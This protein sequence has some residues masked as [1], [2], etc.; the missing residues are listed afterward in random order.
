MSL[1]LIVVL[2]ASKIPRA[3][4]DTEHD[5][6]LQP[7]SR[8]QITCSLQTRQADVSA[9]T[10]EALSATPDR[11]ADPPTPEYR[12]MSASGCAV[13]PSLSVEASV[14]VPVQQCS[15]ISVLVTCK[16]RF[17]LRL[18]TEQSISEVLLVSKIITGGHDRDRCT[19]SK[20]RT[21]VCPEKLQFLARSSSPQTF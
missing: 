8:Q 9:S 13:A 16:P 15:V 5:V 14:V 19:N 10:V 7:V 20:A 12:S 4:Q 18:L 21:L 11:P 2:G 3:I 6:G 17:H 1:A